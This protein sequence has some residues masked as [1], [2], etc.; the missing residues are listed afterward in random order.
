MTLPELTEALVDALRRRDERTFDETM[1]S[2]VGQ[3]EQAS[4]RELTVAL[5]MLQPVIEQVPFGMGVELARLA[6]G[7]V[8]L[9][10]DPLVLL[11]TL[12]LRVSEGLETAVRFPAMWDAEAGGEKLPASEESDKIPFVMGRVRSQESSQAAEAWFTMPEWIPSLLLPLQQAIGRKALARNGNLAARLTA[13]VEAATELTGGA[14]W[15]LGLLLVLDDEKIVVLH[16]QS[17]RG[18]ELT[19]GGIGDN[20]Q[21]HTLL[22]AHLI[23]DPEQGLIA[24]TPPEPAWVAAATTG[25]DL[26][27]AGGLQGQFN[28]VDFHG[29]WIW[30]EG[31]PCDIPKVDGVRVI[32]LD[33]EPYKRSWNTGRIYPLMYPSVTVDRQLSEVE[34]AGWLARVAPSKGFGA[35]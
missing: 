3:A 8:E 32:V 28:L 6:A 15:L 33:P 26:Q 25:P 35:S 7:F 20:F 22:A 13:A 19:I 27:P 12:A 29:D 21:L 18:Y 11:E 31:R 2:I 17:G 1:R 5:E 24:G 30:N 34:A 23:G 16:R 4:P 14:H 10:G 9:G